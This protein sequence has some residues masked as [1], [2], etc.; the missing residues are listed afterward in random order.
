MIKVVIIEDEI[1]ARNK[2]KRFISE[3]DEP[4]EVVAEIDTVE[5]AVNVLENMTVDLIFSDIELLDGNAFEV[6]EQISIT[7]PII[8]TTAYDQFWMNAFESNGIEYLLKPFTQDRFKKAW[9]K[10]LLFKKTDSKENEVLVK[11]QQILNNNK[12]EKNYKKRFTVN[13]HQGIYFLNTEDI[14]FF[15]ANEGIVFAVDIIG[16][17]HLLHESTLKDIEALLSPSE[18]FRINRS[19]L[20]Q[21]QHIERIE[22]YNKNTLAIRMKGQEIHL[23]TSQGSTSAFRKWIE[24]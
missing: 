1:P 8:F 19:E 22:R 10:Y 21:K 4:V 15:E 18:F 20:V 23:I 24:D 9:D 17:K 11:L 12:Q 7:C 16:K 6:Y 3:L 14:T 5:T 2:L 13:A